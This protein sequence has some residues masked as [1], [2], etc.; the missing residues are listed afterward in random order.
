MP[1]K[2]RYRARRIQCSRSGLRVEHLTLGGAA[3]VLE[4]V[5]VERSSESGSGFELAGNGPSLRIKQEEAE[6]RNLS[7]IALMARF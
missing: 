4:F 7:A 1:L 6:R 2:L 5:A 3:V